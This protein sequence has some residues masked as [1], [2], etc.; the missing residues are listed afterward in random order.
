MNPAEHFDA[1][2]DYLYDKDLLPN[3][4]LLT[5]A[6]YRVYLILIYVSFSK[7]NRSYKQNLVFHI[8]TTS[9]YQGNNQEKHSDSQHR[10]Q[11]NVQRIEVGKQLHE[12]VRES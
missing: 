6:L 9:S 7:E 8:S 4:L 2:K 5:K 12:F 3:F 1:A 10:Q 11:N